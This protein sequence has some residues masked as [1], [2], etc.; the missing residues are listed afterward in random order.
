ME[1]SVGYTS[2]AITCSSFD[3]PGFVPNTHSRSPKHGGAG[4][5]TGHEGAEHGGG[6]SSIDVSLVKH[7]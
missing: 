3:R 6:V 2:P 7:K 4:P 1:P 5:E